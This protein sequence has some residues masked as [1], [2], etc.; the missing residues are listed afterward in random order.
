MAKNHIFYDRYARTK[1][2]LFILILIMTF[3][4]LGSGIGILRLSNLKTV[5]AG[6]E[7]VYHD[8]VRPLAQ[9]KTI[10]DCYGLHIIGTANRVLNKTMS[11]E[12]GRDRIKDTT[13][14]IKRSWK[15]YLQTHLVE[16]EKRGAEELRLL[17]ASVDEPSARLMKI[18]LNEDRTALSQFIKD[19]LYQGLEPLMA[20]IDKLVKIQV[21]TAKDINDK[22][23]ARVRLGLSIGSA[24][25]VLSIILFIF[26]LLQWQRF[27]NLLNSF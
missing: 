22:E 24:S 16:E 11:W 5:G 17:F 27:R 2:R 9:L 1:K 10:S 7:T 19:G 15:E 12:Q 20:K 6:L 21:R 8:R 4:S 3:V 26:V 13:A 18:L 14:I 25:I 23:Q